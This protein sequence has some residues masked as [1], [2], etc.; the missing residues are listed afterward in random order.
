M[1]NVS[2]HVPGL[3]VLYLNQPVVAAPPGFAEPF[4]VAVVPV[5][6]VAPLV[7][8]TGAFADV[9]NVSIT[10]NRVPNEFLAI[11]Q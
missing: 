1:P 4:N 10:P 2:L 6:D 11:A 8:T 7:V 9:V 5:I 3:T